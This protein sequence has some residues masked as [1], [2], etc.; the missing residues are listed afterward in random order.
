MIDARIDITI[1]LKQDG[2]NLTFITL[3]FLPQDLTVAD[4]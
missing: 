1:E 2:T 3:P 4:Q